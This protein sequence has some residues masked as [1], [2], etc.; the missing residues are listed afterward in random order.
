MTWPPERSS[1]RER[2][3]KQPF[4]LSMGRLWDEAKNMEALAAVAR[5]LPWPVEVAGDAPAPGLVRGVASGGALRHLGDIEQV[6]MA[7][8]A[9]LL[10][11]LGFLVPVGPGNRSDGVLTRSRTR[12]PAWSIRSIALSGRNRSVM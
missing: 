11:L 1:E 7:V 5:D 12:A 4:A 2:E 8:A 6:V 10:P 3:R 9:R